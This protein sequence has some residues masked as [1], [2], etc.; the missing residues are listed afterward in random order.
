MRPIH[1]GSS[2]YKSIKNYS[3]AKPYLR[4]VIGEYCCY[5][6]FPIFHVPEV[7]HIVS[8]SKDGDMTDWNNLL[9]SCKYC[10]THKGNSVNRQNVDEYMWPDKYN[11]GLAFSYDSS[12]YSIS[13]IEES[14]YP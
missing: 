9:F 3:E 2:P 11:T 5:C 4:E 1:K 10:N 12:T 6:E 8:K 14:P 13:F 7:D